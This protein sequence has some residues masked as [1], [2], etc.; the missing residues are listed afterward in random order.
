MRSVGFGRRNAPGSISLAVSSS[1]LT[2]LRLLQ[3][4]RSH[5]PAR[6]MPQSTTLHTRRDFMPTHKATYQ[7][8]YDMKRRCLN[9]ASANYPR[10]GG[11]GIIVCAR[12]LSY[13]NFVHDMGERPEGLT[14]E[15][16]DSNGNY[17]PSNCRWATKE[18]QRRNQ[19]NRNQN[20]GKTHCSRGHLLEGDNLVPNKNGLRHCRACKV[21]SE[22]ERRAEKRRAAIDAAKG[23]PS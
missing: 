23:E 11:R 21:S 1:R 13:E 4:Y 19:A 12:W 14:I 18:D 15:R 10:Y 7:S 6:L 8:W 5:S 16:I 17:E 2:S 9:P 22:R 20:Y 3:M